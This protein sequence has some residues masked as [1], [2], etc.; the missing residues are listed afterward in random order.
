MQNKYRNFPVFIPIER[1]T[2]M[3]M[4]AFVLVVYTW[5]ENVVIYLFENRI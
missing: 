2:I 4:Q 1:K 3:H 5:A